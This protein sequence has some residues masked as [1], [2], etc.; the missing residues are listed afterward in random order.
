MT[1]LTG[2]NF[3]FRQDNEDLFEQ[4][5]KIRIQR[6][7][8]L[9]IKTQPSLSETESSWLELRES[10]RFARLVRVDR[11]KKLAVWLELLS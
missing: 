3:H 4:F 2:G 10:L 7:E 6:I 11:I 9:E 5:D 8:T 1:A